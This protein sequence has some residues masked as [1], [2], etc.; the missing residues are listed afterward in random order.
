MMIL[1]IMNMIIL[2]SNAPMNVWLVITKHH[3]HF[4]LNNILNNKV[5]FITTNVPIVMKGFLPDQLLLNISKNFQTIKDMFVEL[6]KLYLMIWSP[7][8]NIEGR[9]I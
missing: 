4:K 5:L 2:K 9:N 7:E 6:V 1:T 8:Q 3:T